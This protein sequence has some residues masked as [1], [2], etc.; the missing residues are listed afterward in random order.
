M[1]PNLTRR[2]FITIAGAATGLALLPQLSSAAN[3]KVTWTGRAFGAEA[4]ITLFHPDPTFA[5]TALT[6]CLAEAN[7]LEDVFSLYRPNSQLSKLN[8]AGELTSPA[9]ELV[10]LLHTAQQI[11]QASDGAFDVTVQP[12][13]SLYRDHFQQNGKEASGPLSKNVLKAT[14]L[15]NWKKLEV[16][17]NHIRF[18]DHNMAATL[19]GI[20]QGYITDKI[21]TS[22]RAKGFDN[23]Y[24]DLGEVRALGRYDG[25][26]PWRAG[27][28]NPK[29][30]EIRDHIFE[31]ENQA[32]ATSGGYGTQFDDQGR[33][34]HLF[35]PRKGQSA[36]NW[37]SVSVV[38]PTATLADALSTALSVV[39][40]DKSE[41]ILKHF[42]G[43]KAV[44][45]APDGT[46]SHG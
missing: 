21:A 28:L 5:K 29:T 14:K 18:L 24:V 33:F 40:K 36:H 7:R 20:A 39:S 34:H 2:R 17:T 1:Q 38:A 46:L 8:Q 41:S 11:S 4:A 43:S 26:R 22:L 9:P 30:G 15:V 3:K 31:L 45:I 25:T 37:L 32:L 44:F 6:E 42:P 35:D 13:W 12:L 19:N 23:L 27:L 16:H 10:E